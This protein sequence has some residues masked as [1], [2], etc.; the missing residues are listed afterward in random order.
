MVTAHTDGTDSWQSTAE[1]PRERLVAP[2]PVTDERVEL[3]GIPTAVLTGGEGPPVVLLHGPGDFAATW[4]RVLPE[5][6]ES[7]RVIVPDLPGHGASG[8]GDGKLDADRVGAW[9]AGLIERLCSGPP[10]LVGHLLGGALAA[11]HAA[12][13]GDEVSH[14]VLVDTFGLA[15]LRP[16]PAFAVALFGFVARPTE[17][18]QRRLMR[19]CMAAYDELHADMGAELELLEAYALD[20]ARG[21]DLKAALRALMP[22]FGLPAIPAAVLDRITAPTTLVWGR[23]DLQVRLRV[24]EAAGARFGWPLHVIEDAADDPAVEQP[25]AF[26]AALHRALAPTTAQGGTS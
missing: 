2:L 5:L 3:A 21:P 11:H 12:G 26:L 13:H 20:R 25:E 17:R 10:A 8:L 9:L 4:L 7:Y 15:R 19:R 23:D 6:T 22:R 18:T 24:A 1:T 16:S 14:L